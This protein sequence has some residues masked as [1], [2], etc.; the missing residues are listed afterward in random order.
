[1]R[2]IAITMVMTFHLGQA[3]IHIPGPIIIGQTGVDLFFVLSGFLITSLL[4][5]APPNDWNFVRTFY[6][7]RTLRIFPLYYAVLTVLI[8]VG[9]APSIVFWTYLQ[10]LWIAFGVPVRGPNHFWSLA[11][12]EQFYMVWPFLVL[13]MPRRFLRNCLFLMIAAALLCRIP[14]MALGGSPFYFT[15]ARVDA[16]AC[17]ALLALL[18]SKAS[19]AKFWTLLLGLLLASLATLGILRHSAPEM[20]EQT[21]KFTVL[22]VAYTSAIGLL[23]ASETSWLTR[24]LGSSPLR[25]IGRISYGLY[26]FHPF[27]FEFAINHLR[28]QKQWVA[29]VAAVALSFLCSLISWYG[30]ES[31]FIALKDKLAPS[32]SRFPASVP[33]MSSP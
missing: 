14:L 25:F 28:D 33:A 27:A 3:G 11:V 13:F 12:E 1:M 18:H 23:L 7:R 8:L 16:L 10:N 15:L 6:I 26:V 5:K 4:L 30:M 29:A 20:L 21:L 31:W 22:A 9:R 32:R 24:C 2:A 19:L 17:G